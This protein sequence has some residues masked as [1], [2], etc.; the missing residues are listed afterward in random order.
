MIKFKFYY[1]RTGRNFLS[2]KQK[3]LPSRF[4]L[5]DI[6]PGTFSKNIMKRLSSAKS[7][8]S[9]IWIANGRF[10]GLGI[11]I[12]NKEDRLLKIKKQKLIDKEIKELEQNKIVKK[13]LSLCKL[14]ARF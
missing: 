10:Y 13:Y 2:E 14:S 1:E 3:K 11:I 9:V 12:I 8:G 7:D 6:E 5:E 4:S